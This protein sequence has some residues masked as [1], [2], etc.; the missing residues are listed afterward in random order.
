MPQYE[1]LTTKLILAE[2][3]RIPEVLNY[4]PCEKETKKMN[5]QYL[6]NLVYGIVGEKFRLWIQGT[7]EE[8]NE[9]LATDKN[10]MIAFDPE[11]AA[12]FE[13]STHIST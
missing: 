4:L 2:A 10:L 8:R 9:K 1:Q 7:V 12:A 5:K 13:R 11:I 3:S 6:V